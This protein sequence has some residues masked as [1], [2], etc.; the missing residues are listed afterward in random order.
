[1]PEISVAVHESDLDQELDKEMENVKKE[2]Q[3]LKDALQKEQEPEERQKLKEAI[4]NKEQTL[5]DYKDRRMD[6]QDKL[7]EEDTSPQRT[8]RKPVPTEKMI[9]F[10]KETAQKK[11]K[12][13]LSMYEQW[14]VTV[15]TTRTSL[16]S[17]IPD[18]EIEPL[19]DKVI[20]SKENIIKL[21]LEIREHVTP[22]AGIRRRVDACESISKDL[23]QIAY[24]TMLDEDFDKEQ[25][26]NR[27]LELRDRDSS[28]SIFGAQSQA[29]SGRS[30]H[31]KAQSVAA[32]RLEAAAELAAKEAEY[33]A[34]V[35]EQ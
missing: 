17:N 18:H 13:F 22:D 4:H 26:H 21:F 31:S 7:E 6:L 10:Q 24:D 3:N 20:Q 34:R 5:T 2:L 25:R 29:S 11:V 14:K 8:K 28:H 16:K 15:R 32:S 35:E 27:L 23:V 30:H 12:T 9:A 19:I 1:M 33:E